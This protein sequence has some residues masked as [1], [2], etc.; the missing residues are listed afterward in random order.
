MITKNLKKYL[1]G[2]LVG[3][4]LMLVTIIFFEL[5]TSLIKTVIK[6]GEYHH[7]IISL[8]HDILLSVLV[9]LLCLIPAYF[10]KKESKLFR[11]TLAVYTFLYVLY[12][13]YLIYLFFI[14]DLRLV[15]S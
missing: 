5:R 1:V 3:F 11:I 4:W 12:L 7:L 14:F 13:S 2:F 9:G 6:T 15:F 8:G 10:Y